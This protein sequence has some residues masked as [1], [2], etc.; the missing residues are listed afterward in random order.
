[1]RDL[2]NRSSLPSY[3][4][5]K[6]EF[7]RLVFRGI[8]TSAVPHRGSQSCEEGVLAWMEWRCKSSSSVRLVFSRPCTAQLCRRG[9]RQLGKDTQW[10]QRHD[11]HDMGPCVLYLLCY[12]YDMV[13]IDPWNKYGIYL[14]KKSRTTGLI[15]PFLINIPCF[16]CKWSRNT[17]LPANNHTPSDGR[18]GGGEYRGYNIW[19]LPQNAV[20]F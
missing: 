17:P 12:L 9:R 15:D 1:M 16:V 2:L 8:I 4:V 20:G 13:R 19:L 6:D 18:N 5:V 11:I 3:S 7:A 10:N 14:Y